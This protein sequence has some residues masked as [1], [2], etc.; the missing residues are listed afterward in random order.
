[1]MTEH[2]ATEILF[3][4]IEDATAGGHFKKIADLNTALTA[5]SIVKKALSELQ[6]LREQAAKK[7]DAEK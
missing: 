3:L 5:H 1:M 7:A 2:Q 6:Q 4:V